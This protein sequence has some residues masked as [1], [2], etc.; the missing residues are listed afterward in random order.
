MRRL[1]VFQAPVFPSFK[2]M[3]RQIQKSKTLNFSDKFLLG[4]IKQEAA[5]IYNIF[6]VHHKSSF[7]ELWQK[8]SALKMSNG[9]M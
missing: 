4:N 2:N 3:F 8:T 6:A 9:F 7:K 5:E 1:E